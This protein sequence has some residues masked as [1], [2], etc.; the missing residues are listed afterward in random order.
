MQ[1]SS[2]FDVYTYWTVLYNV[3]GTIKYVHLHSPQ[4]QII[5]LLLLII[6]WIIANICICYDPILNL[7]CSKPVARFKTS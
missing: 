7:T 6:H 4:V 1:I 5:K 2:P 3:E